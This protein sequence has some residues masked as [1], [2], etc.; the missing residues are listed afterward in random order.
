MCLLL[1]KKK[2]NVI[3]FF[4]KVGLLRFFS[5]FTLTPSDFTICFNIVFSIQRILK[6]E[7]TTVDTLVVENWGSSDNYF[8]QSHK[9][10]LNSLI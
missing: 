7:C 5:H 1:S 9:K 2:I 8:I 10:S 4:T 3:L 6:A